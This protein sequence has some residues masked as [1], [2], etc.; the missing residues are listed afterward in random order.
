M[1]LLLVGAGAFLATAPASRID[2]LL[3]CDELLPSVV[4]ES[5]PKITVTRLCLGPLGEV[6]RITTQDELLEWEEAHLPSIGPGKG[7]GP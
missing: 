7:D 5:E 4:S 2:G 6:V 1:V 3:P